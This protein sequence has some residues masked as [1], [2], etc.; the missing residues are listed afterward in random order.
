MSGV[1]HEL[2]LGADFEHVAHCR[3]NLAVGAEDLNAFRRVLEMLDVI[4]G[5][6]GG[7]PHDAAVAALHAPHPVDGI[8]ID[9]AGRRIE[10]DPAEHLQASDVLAREPGAVGR[11]QDVILEDEGLESTILV[12]DRDLLIVERPSEN[13]GR[14]VDMGI[15]EAGNRAH[16]RGRRRK[17][18][19]L[20]KYLGK[21]D[22]RRHAGTADDRNS[23]FEERAATCMG[24]LRVL[25]MGAAHVD[26]SRHARPPAAVAEFPSREIRTEISARPVSRQVS[27]R[28]HH[29]LSG[30][31][32]KPAARSRAG[33][34]RVA[35]GVCPFQLVKIWSVWL[36]MSVLQSGH[37]DPASK[38]LLR[39]KNG[40][41][42]CS[43]RTP[44]SITSLA[45]ASRSG[46]TSRP[47][48]W[49]L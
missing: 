28:L 48:L 18:A 20:P 30:A 1:D 37:R 42:Q 7:E 21:G 34:A 10:D 14:G 3:K 45:R 38:C 35:P 5:I 25:A 49:R 19:N 12:E 6:E 11:G 47:S 13:V 41:M 8:G 23:A 32:R 31:E 27:D 16:D 40:L 9:S 26:R 33:L 2:L 4:V 24:T 17:D 22:N 39:A 46:G 29:L 44:Y 15:H 36:C 43:K